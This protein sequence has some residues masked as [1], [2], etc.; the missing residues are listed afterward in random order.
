VKGTIAACALLCLCSTVG[1]QRSFVTEHQ[2]SERVIGLLDLPDVTANYADDACRMTGLPSLDLFREPSR[3]AP[4]IGNIRLGEHR[5]A[6]CA[7]LFR[8]RGYSVDEEM[9]TQESGYE[10]AAAVVHER[11]DHWFRIALPRGSAWVERA[12]DEDFLPYPEILA[13][14]LSYLMNDWDG[15]LRRSPSA[16]APALPLPAEWKERIPSQIGIQVL[17]VRRSDNEDWMRVRIVTGRCGD[18]STKTV[19]P[20][21]GWVPVHRPDGK[22]TAWF[23]S[24]GC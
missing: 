1:A 24:R 16:K 11:R 17:R 22:P 9:P 21:E 6:G 23:H 20:I 13:R 8:R 3:T 18:D 15:Q 12:K 2:P 14:R 5:D 10:I 19:K 7:L 4:V